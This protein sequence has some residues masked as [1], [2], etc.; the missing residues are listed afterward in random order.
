MASGTSDKPMNAYRL[1]T[2]AYR[3]MRHSASLSLECKMLLYIQRR[4]DYFVK[5]MND[6][7]YL[8]VWSVCCRFIIGSDS[9][10]S[11]WC[12]LRFQYSFESASYW[13]SIGL[14]SANSIQNLTW[15][16]TD[17]FF[18]V[19][20]LQHYRCPITAWFS[21]KFCILSGLCRFSRC[22]WS[23]SSNLISYCGTIMD[24]YDTL[25]RIIVGENINKLK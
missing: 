21:E 5:F 8:S 10:L 22:D 18:C 4:Y 12:R 11:V 15:Y 20:L 19:C 17:C 13:L 24:S 1:L 23:K 9:G 2:H 25:S 3:S 6:W 16:N 14:K 7:V